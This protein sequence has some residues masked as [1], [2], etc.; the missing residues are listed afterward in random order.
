LHLPFLSLVTVERE[1]F[2]S[3]HRALAGGVLF[4]ANSQR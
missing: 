3:N 1:Q 4:A 2:L